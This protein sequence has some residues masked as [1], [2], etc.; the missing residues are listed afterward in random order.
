MAISDLTDYD[1][2]CRYEPVLRF[3]RGEI[4]FPTDIER[5]V[6]ACSLWV[7][8]ADGHEERLLAEGEVNLR[9]LA[10]QRHLEPGVVQYLKFVDDLSL[11]D[12]TR[13]VI[14]GQRLAARALDRGWEPGQG[15]LAR[16]GYLSRLVDALFTLTLLARGKVPGATAAVAERESRR[17][18]EDAEKYVYYARV[19]RDGGWIGLQ[20][21]YFYHYD[22][23][24]TGFNGVND[25]EADW[26]TILVFL[27]TKPDGEIIPRWVVYSCH[28]FYGDDLRRR[29][30]DD[31]ELERIGDHPVAYIGA[32][33]HAAYY[34]PG[35]Y[36][37]SSPIPLFARLNPLLDGLQKFWDRLLRRQNRA[38]RRRHNLLAIP[39]VEYARGDGASIGPGQSQE[40]QAVLLNPPQPW[41]LDYRGLWGLYAR[42]PTGGENA[43]AGP[44]YNRDGTPRSAWYDPLAYAGLAAVPP[45]PVEQDLLERRYQA[46]STRQNELERQV[47]EKLEALHAQSVELR[48][49]RSYPN[50]R[51]E[52]ERRSEA[53]K[54]LEN[55]I[56]SMRRERSQ[57]ESVLDALAL[58]IA[59]LQAGQEDP[60]QAHI[61]VLQRPF[62]P[63]ELRFDRLAE[64]WAAVSIGLLLV[65]FVLIV[66]LSPGHI[67]LGVLLVLTVFLL[68]EAVFRDHFK[69]TIAWLT[70]ILA[71]FA[72]LLMIY[73]FYWQI[74][75]GTLLLGGIYLTWQNLREAAV[76]KRKKV[77]PR[78]E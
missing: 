24:R 31:Q 58:R 1:L 60:P 16:V 54:D 8:H 78:P 71:V 56:K 5:Y 74:I 50:L 69:Q 63:R 22:D 12:I 41:L 27:Y 34:R 68:V 39:F 43:P 64:W 40:W 76:L 61:K 6:Q 51:T 20:Y 77:K 46:L 38:Q 49:M 67:P 28:D 70:T 55:E 66:T 2:L 47:A 10:E 17:I 11:S 73:T 29:W 52:A 25:H 7:S 30:D 13:Q 32:G 42:D 14:K 18:Q 37:I 33:S 9:N 23:W 15:R 26:E 35:E 62:S 53:L 75:I 48:A 36:L 19:I 44:M 65:A 4:Y 3:T 72:G 45:P 21:W 59:N 57:N